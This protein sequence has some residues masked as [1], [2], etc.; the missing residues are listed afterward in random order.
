MGRVTV[1]LN[2]RS[3]RLNCGDGDEHRI[4]ELASHIRTKVEAIISEFGQV[5]EERLLLMAALMVTD[6]LFDLREREVKFEHQGAPNEGV[7]EP[8]IAPEAPALKTEEASVAASE[9]E[10]AGVEINDAPPP[11]PPP[12]P[13]I[14]KP[15]TPDPQLKLPQKT[16]FVRPSLASRKRIPTS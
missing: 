6:E 2:N 16:G 13:T 7:M 15:S 10:M 11:K 12:A 5:G 3:Y 8:D 14:E 1:T 4:A 9:V